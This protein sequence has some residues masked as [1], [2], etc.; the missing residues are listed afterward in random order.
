MKLEVLWQI[1]E[2]YWKIKLHKNPSSERRVVP[3]GRTDVRVVA[4]RYCANAHKNWATQR[5]KEK[6]KLVLRYAMKAYG[7]VEIKLHS[8]LTSALGK[9]ASR[10]GR[11]NPNE[12]TSITP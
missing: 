3:Y 2:K 1:F 6:I 8:F 5:S 4:F 12:T 11:F 7:E 9:N 10:H